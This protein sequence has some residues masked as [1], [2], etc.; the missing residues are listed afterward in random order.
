MLNKGRAC[1]TAFRHLLTLSCAPP[2]LQVRSI[3]MDK[4]TPD[5]VTVMESAG[6]NA[7][8]NDFFEARLPKDFV[9]PHR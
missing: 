6:G 7:Q 1:S 5:L 3:T 4:W 8:A 9:R 2:P